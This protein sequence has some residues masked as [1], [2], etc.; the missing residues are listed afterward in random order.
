MDIG[1]YVDVLVRGKV[2]HNAVWDIAKVIDIEDKRIKIK[3]NEG[4]GTVLN[5]SINQIKGLRHYT[6]IPYHSP[7]Y[8]H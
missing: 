1:Q 5:G 7:N 8:H 2:Q 4:H 3:L 6:H